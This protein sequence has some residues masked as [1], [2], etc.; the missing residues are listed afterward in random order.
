MEAIQLDLFSPINEAKEKTE[1]CR[2]WLSAVKNDCGVYTIN[3]RRY[4]A[5]SKKCYLK[6]KVALSY[7]Y[8]YFANS[9]GS[10]DYGWGHPLCDDYDDE[11]HS[12]YDDP[13]QLVAELT[14]WL[15]KDISE[16]RNLDATGRSELIKLIPRI[17][18]DFYK[19][20]V[21]DGN[22]TEPNNQ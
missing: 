9:G 14:D 16:N 12:V 20:A 10:N 7:P 1:L 4:E 13:F 17:L 3:T 6:L 15:A 22:P 18:E 2:T 11:R 5:K 8:I 19:D 21:K